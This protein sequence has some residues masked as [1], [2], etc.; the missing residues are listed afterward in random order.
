MPCTQPAV[1]QGSGELHKC[2]TKSFHT[3]KGQ[4][5]GLSLR[6]YLDARS[7]CAE[8]LPDF[9][10]LRRPM[11]LCSSQT[12]ICINRFYL[13]NILQTHPIF[14]TGTTTTT[15]SKSPFSS[16]GLLQLSLD[17]IPQIFS[18]PLSSVLW[19]TD[20]VIL[21]IRKQVW[22]CWWFAKS[23]LMDKSKK[24]KK[25]KLPSEYGVQ[26]L[27]GSITSSPICWASWE[28]LSSTHTPSWDLS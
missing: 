23:T 13:L 8:F 27:P 21:K 26:I 22:W 25:K 5:L 11:E 3:F 4:G 1:T 20:K 18:D 28:L 10:L 24:K 17:W 19:T 7:E 2:K 16:S 15:W 6:T 14:F 9:K 12:T